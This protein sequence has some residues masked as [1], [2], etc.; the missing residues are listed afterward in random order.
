MA[1]AADDRTDFPI[2]YIVAHL[3]EPQFIDTRLVEVAKLLEPGIE[4][5]LYKTREL[6]RKNPGA[7][8]PSERL[9][10]SPAA[11]QAVVKNVALERAF[12]QI[13]REVQDRLS[14]DPESI[15][16]LRQFL[17]DGTVS[18]SDDDAKIE[19]AGVADRFVFL[20]KAGNRWYIENRQTEEK[21]K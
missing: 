12:F 21:K 8:A 6:Q 14:G 19:L 15:K 13:V 11:F 16:T 1:A 18:G 17:R 7:Y 20:K 10:E 4:I 5:E 3:M 9:P 2:R